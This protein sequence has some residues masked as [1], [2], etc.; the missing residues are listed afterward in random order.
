VAA[1]EEVTSPDQHKPGPIRAARVGAAITVVLLLAML[2]G[3]HKG[4]IEDIFLVLTAAVIVG[5]LVGDWLLRRN[6]LR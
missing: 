2:C 6:G 3:N 4:R 5:A 1:E